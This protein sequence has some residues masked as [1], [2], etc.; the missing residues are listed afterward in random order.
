[1]SAAIQCALDLLLFR[2]QGVEGHVGLRL[3][4]WL[5][6]HLAQVIRVEPGGYDVPDLLPR[7]LQF[8]ALVEVSDAGED[9]HERGR[10]FEGGDARADRL[11]LVGGQVFE[12]VEAWFRLFWL[13]LFP[14]R[15][16]V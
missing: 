4:V 11:E 5:L 2:V 9:L 13:A 16:A 3:F 7:E 6:A 8:A 14:R 10:L 1:M 15:R 12:E